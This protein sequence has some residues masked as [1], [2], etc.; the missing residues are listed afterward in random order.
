MTLL[1]CL[2]RDV[3]LRRLEPVLAALARA[4]HRVH[5]W[6]DAFSPAAAARLRGVCDVQPSPCDDDDWWAVMRRVHWSRDYVQT[7]ERAWDAMPDERHAAKTAAPALFSSTVERTPLRYRPGR[8]TLDA[9][10]RALEK[11]RGQSPCLADRISSLAPDVVVACPAPRCGSRYPDYLFA[12]SRL[13]LRTAVI[14]DGPCE[15]RCGPPLRP[16]PS[17]LLVWNDDE[18]AAAVARDDAMSGR[19]VVVGPATLAAWDAASLHGDSLAVLGQR[20]GLL[21]A[22]E[23]VLYAGSD[24][25]KASYREPALAERIASAIASRPSTAHLRFV[26]RPHPE[27]RH[28]WKGR[29]VH[30]DDDPRPIVLRARAVVGVRTRLLAEAAAAG[31]PAIV[32]DAPGAAEGGVRVRSMLAGLPTGTSAEQ[33][34]DRLEAVLQASR[35]GGRRDGTDPSG[36]AVRATVMALEA[37]ARAEAPRA[38]GPALAA[39]LRPLL[40]APVAVRQAGRARRR[41]QKETKR[42]VRKAR[43]RAARRARRTIRSVS[44]RRLAVRAFVLGSSESNEVAQLEAARAT[45][46]AVTDLARRGGPIVVGPWLS[47]AGFELLYWIPFVRWAKA[48]GN[49][50]A[51]RLV[52]VSRGGAQPWYSDIATRYVDLLSLYG[53]DEFR[54]HN[55]RRIDEQGGQKQRGRAEFEHDIFQRV[56]ERAGLRQAQWLHPSLMYNLFNLFWMQRAPAS[57]VQRFT[58]HRRLAPPDVRDVLDLP[59]SFIAAKFYTNASFPDSPENRAFVSQLLR[60]LTARHDVVLLNTGINFDDHGEFSPGESAR[61]HAV[62]QHLTPA[63]NLRVQTG[64]V[65]AAAAY[66]GTYGGF[67]YVAPLCGTDAI[68]FYSEPSL[69]RHDHLEMARRVFDEVGGARFLAAHRDELTFLDSVLGGPARPVAGAATH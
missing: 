43:D 52:V 34:V 65:S 58:V 40:W 49:I 10:L 64:I 39:A 67:S 24:L 31:C 46:E 69:F 45:C 20:L 32:F 3:T 5:V 11:A 42:Y 7:L 50:R 2:D 55:E 27:W 57:L 63:D 12:A 14:T 62:S 23:F 22:D 28:V 25:G 17:R 4:E 53:V 66:V 48:Y 60:R 47:E 21:P 15:I 30:D 1:F 13:G 51:D 29:P 36:A 16:R 61:L 41:G 44:E 37:L 35:I 59:A 9:T 33:V 56:T 8:R 19:V 6:L 68:T 54:E 18:A 26:A 38:T